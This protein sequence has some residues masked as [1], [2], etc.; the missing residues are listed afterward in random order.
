M[1]KN[2][3][4]SKE[5][6]GETQKLVSEETFLPGLIDTRMIVNQMVPQ[7]GGADTATTNFADEEKP[8]IISA[9]PVSNKDELD[10]EYTRI[11]DF[12]T[13]PVLLT[14][15]IWKKP[16]L[17]G[18]ITGDIIFNTDIGALLASKTIWKNKIEGFKMARGDF[19]L[20]VLMNANPFQ[21][22]ALYTH[23]LP[24]RTTMM[25]ELVAMRNVNNT[26]KS[27]QPGGLLTTGDKGLE[28]V[29][30][31]LAPDYWYHLVT[32][33]YDW[34]TV[35]ITVFSELESG[36]LEVQDVEVSIYGWF[37]NFELSAPMVPQSSGSKSKKSYKAKTLNESDL[38]SK[39]RPLSSSLALVGAIA[40]GVSA[41]PQLAVYS[42]PISWVA[43]GLAGLASAFGYSKR[44]V[45]TPPQVVARQYGKYMATGDGADNSVNMGLFVDSSVKRTVLSLTG[46]DEMS[47]AFI[48]TRSA[49]LYDVSWP[50]SALTND[51]IYSLLV[52]PLNLKKTHVYTSGPK[53]VTIT[54][55]PPIHYLRNNFGSWRGSVVVDLV[56]LKTKFHT[57]R[58]D[59]T[60]TPYEG[61]GAT[62]P[63]TSTS[64]FALREIV[65]LSTTDRIRLTLP[66]MPS[67]PY[68]S[69]NEASGT[70]I[71]KVLNGLRCPE[72]CSDNVQ[73]MVFVSGGSD[74]EFQAPG[75]VTAVPLIPQVD[76]GILSL[77]T[78]ESA[79][80]GNATVTPYSTFSST[81][82]GDSFNSIK[83]L[84]NRFTVV[85]TTFNIVGNTADYA[86]LAIWPWFCGV[87]SITAGVQDLGKVGGDAYSIVA[88][89]YGFYHGTARIM[90]TTPG[91]ISSATINNDPT[92]S[93]YLVPGGLVSGSCIC[94]GPNVPFSFGDYSASARGTS[95][96]TVFD[97]SVGCFSV[98][99]PPY[100]RSRGSQLFV[101]T[102][103]A[104]SGVP[105]DVS[106]HL[107]N[108]VIV[109]YKGCV[110]NT[111]Y[112][113]FGDDFT[114]SYFLGAPPLFVS[115]V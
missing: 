92:C 1:I 36:A 96:H 12:M 88:P 70:L 66:C 6:C 9:E 20:R 84:L 112:R 50:V 78:N 86:S 110:A 30:P 76:D 39:D 95:G 5:F 83:Q 65:D 43:N 25:P 28:I 42:V 111:F 100:S 3:E 98:S 56:F 69:Q 72:T 82:I 62:L 32:P 97:K 19:H 63:T 102:K 34:G 71:V 57:G 59:I 52:T 53:T 74:F 64:Q 115:S 44:I 48:K 79:V 80:V 11:S 35:Y 26:T 90:M 18:P 107:S 41:I 77:D 108:V 105:V 91:A 14:S 113:S 15:Y 49:F 29:V 31:F 33:K 17:G 38:I 89:M 23:F 93:A 8:I 109:G 103:A 94:P 114:L 45:E 81:S 68:L 85:N 61:A 16:A 37:E 22:G 73:M 13:K 67:S 51:T 24:C 104:D 101:Q 40:T 58:L 60:W 106:Q 27:M 7:A 2:I 47:F 4:I 99:V 54:T 10:D 87:K 21:Q 55:G 75:G 46:E